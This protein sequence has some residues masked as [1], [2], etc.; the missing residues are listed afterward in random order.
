MSE[1]SHEMIDDLLDEGNEQAPP[2]DVEA[3]EID[4]VEVT[5]EEGRQQ[6]DELREVTQQ[7][8]SEI[9]AAYLE[10][11]SGFE[12]TWDEGLREELIGAFGTLL[13]ASRL[14][15][16]SVRDGESL[17]QGITDSGGRALGAVSAIDAAMVK[18]QQMDEEA[19][20]E[21]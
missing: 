19:T 16:R 1:A 20:D 14:W 5:Y 10:E 11:T 15:A 8:A 21:D 3:L 13:A 7:R 17:S 4:D 9:E 18:V 6:Y 12:E 2:E